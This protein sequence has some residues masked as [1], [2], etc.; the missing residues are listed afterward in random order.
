MKK[1][2]IGVAICNNHTNFHKNR[3]TPS[4]QNLVY[5]Q[6]DTQTH[7]QTHIRTDILQKPLF[8]FQG[9]PKRIFPL[10]SQNRIFGRSQYFLYTK[11]YGRK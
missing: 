10:K 9:T 1:T 11:V 4:V 5:R 2:P 8:L 7:R 6:T 3:I